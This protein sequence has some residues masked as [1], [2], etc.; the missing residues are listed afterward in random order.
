MPKAAP[1]AAPAPSNV[2]EFPLGKSTAF[3]S[4]SF[5]GS[6][7]NW[8][9]YNPDILLSRKG[10][11]IY[12]KMVVDEQVQA[13]TK[14]KRDAILSR[15]WDFTFESNTTLSTEEQK[16][17][18][19]LMKELVAQMK[20]SFTDSMAYV[21]RSSR[22]GFSISEKI[23]DLAE[24]GGKA[25]Y[26]CIE[27]RP[28]PPYT[29]Y[30]S[31]D[32]YGNMTEFGQR[33]AGQM[34]VLDLTKFVHFVSNPDEDLWY[35]RSELRT[36]YRS[37]YFKDVLLKM[38]S[39][40]LE[41]MA[42]GFL[43]ASNPT[44]DATALSPQD[45]A[46]L[47]SALDNVKNISGLMM[48]AGWKLDVTQASGE[49]GAFSQAIEYHDLAIA[50]ALL[51]PNLLGVSNTG[52]KTGSYSQAQTQLEAFFWTLN[53]DSNR[54][55]E[56]LQQQ[57][58]MDLYVANFGDGQY[59]C[60]KFKPASEEFIK[61]VVGQWA[62]LINADSVVTT[63]ADEAHLRAILNM[64]QRGPDDKPLITP[65]QQA[66]ADA[67]KQ[68]SG[69]GG[70]SVT[71]GGG[72]KAAPMGANDSD[73]NY[74]RRMRFGFDESEARDQD[75]KWT[76]GGASMSDDERVAVGSYISDGFK[77]INAYAAGKTDGWSKDRLAQAKYEAS[78]LDR[79]IERSSLPQAA[80]VYRGFNHQ[81][82]FANPSAIV[83]KTIGAEKFVS[84]SK[85]DFLAMTYAGS[86][87]KP[88]GI[89][90]KITIPKGAH[91]LDITEATGRDNGEHEVVLSRAA[92]F[93]VT[94]AQEAHGVK[95]FTA[96][97]VP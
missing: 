94:G 62:A 5:L 34:R 79:A 13:A 18:I 6:T 47:E 73:N 7:L 32:A 40:W 78:N 56:T 42:G 52:S 86:G 90:F 14:F 84:T 60:F 69:G 85:S 11:E 33:A 55:E 48:P 43:T 61:W 28:K 4:N 92:K 93:R 15:Q 59:P 2:T 68:Q 83:G 35:G 75:G 58:F 49:G 44:A 67:Q 63:E 16:S 50:K 74:S 9:R 41:R 3:A 46:A 19:E 17:R 76:S 95:I 65:A 70:P 96:E 77:D 10:L 30:F 21:M 91:A 80:I 37:W 31:T 81:A 25:Y 22:H 89:V 38:Q 45:R 88:D 51:V 64:P 39:L 97:M 53:A 57:L 26:A 1:A 8:P 24:I 29:F 12:D 72:S 54:L 82:L 66:A 20:G 23:F 87:A 71:P 36:A 27:L